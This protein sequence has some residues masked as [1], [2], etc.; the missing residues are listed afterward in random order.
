MVPLHAFSISY[1]PESERLYGRKERDWEIDSIS[2]GK[3]VDASGVLLE[4]GRLLASSVAH[5][6][7][8]SFYLITEDSLESLYASREVFEQRLGPWMV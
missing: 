7:S 8:E 6:G 1:E 4:S 2:I 5:C 3:D